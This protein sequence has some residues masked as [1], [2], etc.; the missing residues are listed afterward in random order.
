MTN[1]LARVRAA[2]PPAAASA[3]FAV[4]AL[5]LALRLYGLNWDDGYAWTPHPDERAI[6]GYAAQI[7]TP[8]LSDLGVL[9]DAE[10]SPLNPRWFPYGSFPLY[11]LRAVHWLAEFALYADIPDMRP[12]AR[13]IS[14]L[15]D[16]GTVGAVYLLGKALW[17]RRAALIAALIVALAVVHIQLSHFFAVDTLLA[18]FCVMSAIFLV[19]VARRGRAADSVLAGVFVA[20]A[21]ATKIS[22]A[23]LLAAYCAAHLISAFGLSPAAPHFRRPL[24]AD[25]VIAAALNAAAGGLA[26]LIAFFIFQPYAILDFARF[27]ADVSQQ[28]EM[29]RRIVD[30]PYTRQY[31]DTTP[32]WY[33]IRQLAVWGFGLPLGALAWASLGYAAVRGMGIRAALAY[34]ALGIALPAAI[35]ALSVSSLAVICAAGIASAA[36]IATIPARKPGARLDAILLAW[37]IPYFIVM[38]AFDVKFMRYM[39]PIAPF[40]ALFAAKAA[41]DIW[42]L[43][44]RPRGFA[45][46]VAK[47]AA[48]G[49]G[50]AVMLAAALYAIAYS[51]IYATPH[52]AVRASEY[53]RDILP[54]RSTILKEHWE[55][56]L[57]NLGE[58]EIRELPIYDPDTRAKARALANDLADADAIALYSNRLYGTVSRLPERYPLS[59]AF[60]ETLFSRQLGYA[61]AAAFAAYPN[62]LGIAFADETFARPDLP[63]PRFPNLPGGVS[64]GYADESFTVYDHPKVMIFAN[65][66]RLSA[67]DISE[68]I[69]SA[70]GDAFPPAAAPSAAESQLEGARLMMTESRAAAQRAGGTWSEI[71]ASSGGQDDERRASPLWIAVWLLAAQA[72]ALLAFPLA[73]AAFRPLAD[74]GWILAK[75]LGLLA[76]GLAVWLM[77]SLEI[78]PFGRTPI[79]ISAAGLGVLSAVSFAFN[80]AEMV[81]FF[82]KRWKT[83]AAAEM[84]FL[85]AFFA[86]LLIRMANP[87]LWHPWRGGEKPM[88]MAYLNAVVKSSYM[89]PYDPWFG[90]G[91]LNYYYWGQFLVAA[92]IRATGAVPEVAINIAIPLF[93]A[94]TAALAYSVSYNLAAAAPL[95]ARIRGMM[96][97]RRAVSPVIAG[98]LGAAFVAVIGNLDGAAQTIGNA[99]RAV[100]Q[101]LPP[102]EFDFWRSSRMM[103]PDPPGWEITEFPFFTFLFA[104][105]HAHLFALPFTLLAIGCAAAFVLDADAR[106]PIWTPANILRLAAL[107]LTVGALRAINT[108]DYP[109]YLALA[110]AALAVRE[111]LAHGGLALY[112][113]LRAAAQGAMVFAIGFAA[114]LPYHMSFET[115]FFGIETTTN[116]TTLSQFLGI[117]GL[118]IFAAA[119]LCVWELRRPLVAALSQSA[120][121]FADLRAGL[122]SDGGMAA[123]P[124]ARDDRAYARHPHPSPLPSREMGFVDC[125]SRL[126][127][128]ASQSAAARRP[129]PSPSRDRGFV[130]RDSRLDSPASQSAAAR[131][132]SPLPSREMGFSA[133][134]SLD[135]PL[136]VALAA[137]VVLAAGFALTA[138]LTGWAWTTFA[139]CAAMVCLF[140]AVG[141]RA[142]TA[143]PPDRPLAFASLIAA[144]GFSIV[145][146]LDVVRVEGDIERM[147]T[148]FKFYL[149]VWVLLALASAFAV[150]RLAGALGFGLSGVGVAQRSRVRIAWTIALCALIAASAIYPAMGTRDRLRDRFHDRTIPLTLDG[151]AYAEGTVYRDPKGAV[152][153]SEDMAAIRWLRDNA[154]GSPIVLEASVPSYQWGGRVS[155]HTGLPGVVGWEWHQQQQR[156]DYRD[157]VSARVRDVN[158]IYSTSDP[159]AAAALMKKYGVFFIY[160]GAL[161]RLYYPTDGVAKFSDGRMG[162]LETVF[163][164]DGVVIYRVADSAA[165]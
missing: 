34:A 136:A 3:V 165:D 123:A 1:L 95:R 9:L 19:R 80:R 124:S 64:L 52:P 33:H 44:S 31:I 46:G 30:F 149:Q 129:S 151:L 114:F 105:P 32:Y 134:G 160:M 23:P 59:R 142:L 49:L 57:P 75:P 147:N 47:T 29:A 132:P 14:A 43:V 113:A 63:A 66:S 96:G 109:T 148:V 76:I 37:V 102:A 107:G 51:R 146:A 56:S 11:L 7:S 135:G 104:D 18:L 140:A 24:I 138:A 53:L 137:F 120:R 84:V 26:A 92:L 25:S 119:S 13:A 73:F 150:W 79:V 81:D 85:A 156:W 99:W 111:Y 50:I 61:P 55:E 89:P 93:Y 69:I 161:E 15:A 27:Y 28:S 125:D 38:G 16:A 164:S 108:W 2:R 45:G 17:S 144:A 139:L 106:R 97:R 94:L 62:L 71:F 6:L 117:S 83:V 4:M 143:A 68:R 141:V 122:E 158:R 74:R 87:D 72:A 112:P 77:A 41:M 35:L 67:D 54:E 22:A 36:V 127:S 10:R 86:F 78:L 90:G 115:F 152:D 65:V 58:Y 155:I 40:L 70:A 128:P 116:T 103:P 98:L 118:F 21:L 130:D 163:E 154:D 88:D 60:Y 39:L 133:R 12:L 121:L 42:G 20:L 126:V 162:G 91:Y 110:F 48:L 82:R 159:T 100:V 5:A 157:D 153:L 101:G 145:A 8:P 131:R